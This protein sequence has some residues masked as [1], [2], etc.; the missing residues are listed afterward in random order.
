MARTNLIRAAIA[1][2]ALLIVNSG[3]LVAFPRASVFYMANVVLHLALGLALMAVA[4]GFVKR[5]PQPA[6]TFLLAGLGN[7]TTVRYIAPL[8]VAAQVTNSSFVA[9]ADLAAVGAQPNGAPVT[10]PVR[11]VAR[12]QRIQVVSW[13]PATVVARLDPVISQQVA[14][15]VDRGAVPPGFTAGQPTVSPATVSISGASSLVSQ[16]ASALARVAIDPTGANVDTNVDLV[17]VDARGN[18]VSPVTIQPSSVHVTIPVGEQQVNRTLPVVP[19]VTGNLAPGYAILDVTVTPLTA[20]VSGSGSAMEALT[21]VPTAPISV[22]G[23]TTDLTATVALQPPTGI[24]VLESGGVQVHIQVMV[25]TGSR[26]FGAGVLLTGARSDRTYSLSVP[27]VL[28]TLGGSSNALDQA[29]P[30]GLYVTA[31]VAGL[32]AGTFS[33]SVRFTPPPG[34]SLVAISPSSV[35]VTVTA[36]APSPSPSPTATLNPGA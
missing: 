11:V 10:V 12:D 18:V 17:A 35:Q 27:D 31:S 5:H 9:T 7:V 34:T 4:L 2:L 19:N 6:G 15:Q 14:V 32:D 20:T 21:G 13:E 36:P 16:V 25:E 28:V 1:G 29:D 23:R 22:A 30:A 33:V 26:S 24:A 3:Y 8:D